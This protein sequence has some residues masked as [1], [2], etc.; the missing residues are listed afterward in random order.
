[1]LKVTDRKRFMHVFYLL[2]V[3]DAS[4]RNARRHEVKWCDSEIDQRK[5]SEF[6][7]L[8]EVQV[9]GVDLLIAICFQCSQ[10]VLHLALQMV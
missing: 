4:H 5:S 8:E 6:R 9:Y 7:V 1:M 3:K 2:V 10:I